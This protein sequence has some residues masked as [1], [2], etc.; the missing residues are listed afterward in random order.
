MK[1][2]D[3]KNILVGCGVEAG[4]H[5]GQHQYNVFVGV[6]EMGPHCLRR[7]HPVMMIIK[8]GTWTSYL[9]ASGP[10]RLRVNHQK[11]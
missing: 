8:H 1:V 7:K 6:A 5:T 9:G 3:L 10:V 2:T 4:T 11:D